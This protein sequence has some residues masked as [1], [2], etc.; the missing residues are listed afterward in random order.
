[1]PHVERGRDVQWYEDK[2]IAACPVFF[3]FFLVMFEI[4]SGAFFT[5]PH[6]IRESILPAHSSH[7]FY[8]ESKGSPTYLSLAVWLLHVQERIKENSAAESSFFL[9]NLFLYI[10]MCTLIYLLLRF[11]SSLLTESG[12]V[13]SSS[14]AKLRTTLILSKEMIKHASTDSS[15]HKFVFLLPSVCSV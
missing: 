5:S 13:V 6:N 14:P 10:I 3:F 15:T 7:S 1:M 4:Y 11:L 12:D 2:Y 8:L 9:I